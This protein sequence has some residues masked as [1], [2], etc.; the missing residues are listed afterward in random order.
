MGTCIE[1]ENR[2]TG[3]SRHTG[4]LQDV[5][6][7]QNAEVMVKKH[8]SVRYPVVT[9]H[10]VD[11][12]YGLYAKVITRTGYNLL[13]ATALASMEHSRQYDRLPFLMHWS[14]IA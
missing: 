13:L 9:R 8:D 4:F 6:R 12:R 10:A 14:A 11:T 7:Y 5:S 1:D 3:T 2:T